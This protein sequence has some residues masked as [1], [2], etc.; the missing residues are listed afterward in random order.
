MRVLHFSAEPICDERLMLQAELRG[1]ADALLPGRVRN[2]TTLEAVPQARPNDV[3]VYLVNNQPDVV[4]F[5]MHGTP[6][7]LMLCDAYLDPKLYGTEDLKAALDGLGVKLAVLNA[8]ESKDV[9]E[10]IVE[11]VDV[12]IGTK[13]TLSDD[14]AIVF[15]EVFY[16]SL[17]VGLSI[18]KSYD[19]AMRELDDVSEDASD[20]Y[21]KL[22]REEGLDQHKF[23]EAAADREVPAV[24][25]TTEEVEPGQKK[26]GG[27]SARDDEDRKHADTQHRLR[28]AAA[29]LE[30]VRHGAARE[31]RDNAEKV[32]W[33]LG[34][35]A[36]GS[37]FAGFYPSFSE[38]EFFQW[39]D[40]AFG[41]IQLNVWL[42]FAF[43]IAPPTI[44][45][46][47]YYWLKRPL[48]EAERAAFGL[49]LKSP[50]TVD[51]E[52]IAARAEALVT[53]MDESNKALFDVLTGGN[54]DA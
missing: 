33:V 2:D 36:V 11:H 20:W 44:Y 27:A 45:L 43:F 3:D 31:A 38:L 46:V 52:E 9:A 1:I 35:A 49:A 28:S 14:H 13:R 37:L 17:Q 47:E 19:A 42:L 48:E 5:S 12:V 32:Y 4:H 24:R 51:P 22:C 54:S 15:S 16:K 8:C 29:R 40:R 23:V 7:G 41:W 26:R 50:E 39:L 25:E 34:F 18:E 6:E 30:A 10:A 21:I 53:E